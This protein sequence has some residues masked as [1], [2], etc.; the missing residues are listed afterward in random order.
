MRLI[1]I[2]AVLF[3][4]LCSCGARSS[5]LEIEF[6]ASTPEFEKAASEY[7]SIWA[8]QGEII[9]EALGRYSGSA[10]PELRL[11]VIVFEGVSNSGRP[12]GPLRLRASYSEPVKRATI[13]HELLHRYLIQ[14]SGLDACYPEVHDIMAASALTAQGLSLVT[15][16]KCGA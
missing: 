12:G 13:S 6:V 14:V 3:C 9:T 2:F 4:L 5:R 10:L 8:S 11:Q 16:R 15:C 1:T 7:R